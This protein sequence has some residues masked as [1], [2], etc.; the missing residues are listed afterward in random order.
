MGYRRSRRCPDAGMRRNPGAAHCLAR[1]ASR[2]VRARPRQIGRGAALLRS[3]DRG[4]CAG[5]GVPWQG[6]ARPAQARHVSQRRRRH[7]SAPSHAPH[8]HRAHASILH[9]PL[10]RKLLTHKT[11]LQLFLTIKRVNVRKR[12]KRGRD[13]DVK[14]EFRKGEAQSCPAAN[15]ARSSAINLLIHQP[16]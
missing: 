16:N 3:L 7:E 2:C 13:H 4:G 1:L 12:T 5:C 8:P 14:R 10:A 9:Y 15:V 11:F 6:Q